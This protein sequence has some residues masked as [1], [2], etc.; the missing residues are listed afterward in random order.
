MPAI[1]AR[2]TVDVSRSKVTRPRQELKRVCIEGIFLM[3]KLLPSSLMAREQRSSSMCKARPIRER[4][5]KMAMPSLDLLPRCC[6]ILSRV[7]P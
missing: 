2:R 4:D 3:F 6:R 5:I 1:C 7:V